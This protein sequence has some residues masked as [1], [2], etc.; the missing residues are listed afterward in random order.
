M[1][2]HQRVVENGFSSNFMVV[3]AL[4]DMYAK[5]GTIHKAQELLDKMHDIDIVLWIVMIIW[6]VKNGYIKRDYELFIKMPHPNAISW[7]IK[8]VSYA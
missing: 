3:N 6:Y 7:N 1:K 2:I 4:I 8:I 5:S